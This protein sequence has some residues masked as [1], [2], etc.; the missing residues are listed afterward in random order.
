MLTLW[1]LRPVS[2][3]A[4]VGAHNAVVWNRVNLSPAAAR[5]SAFGAAHGP[6]KALEA[7][8]PRSSIKTI[9]T[10]GASGG[11]RIGTIGSNDEFGSFASYDVSPTG[12]GSGIG[13]T[14]RP[15]VRCSM[16]VC[17]L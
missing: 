4:R 11:G 17:L 2:I 16:F 14:S 6:P 12:T 7:P 8:K 9:R 10:F 5:R 1:W 15:V 13:R 3:A